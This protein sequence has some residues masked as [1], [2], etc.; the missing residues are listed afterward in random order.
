MFSLPQAHAKLNEGTSLAV[1]IATPSMVQRRPEKQGKP[2]KI[3]CQATER[4]A[5]FDGRYNGSRICVVDFIA[6]DNL[7]NG[8]TG[9]WLQQNDVGERK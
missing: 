4:I 6:C 2:A 7:P 9:L 3:T 8:G 5:A 1:P